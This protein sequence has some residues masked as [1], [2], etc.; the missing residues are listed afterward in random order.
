MTEQCICEHYTN[1]KIK[2]SPR[3]PI[4]GARHEM[5]MA[6][7]V[8][9]WRIPNDNPDEVVAYRKCD[10]TMTIGEIHR[11]INVIERLMAEI[12]A[13]RNQGHDAILIGHV[14]NIL[15]GDA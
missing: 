8:H 4:H 10:E 11:R 14:A 12:E 2:R 9:E 13:C 5:E 7:Y 6:E 15:E 1:F 3:C